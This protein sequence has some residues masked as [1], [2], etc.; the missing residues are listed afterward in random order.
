MPQRYDANEKVS[1]R[2]VIAKNFVG[3]VMWGL[4]SVIGATVVLS[5]LLGVLRRLDF[6]P[7]IA[8][9]VLQIQDAI[10]IRR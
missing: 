4:G 2:A 10:E 9:S 1:W 3:G 8:E 7:M 5:L 6:I